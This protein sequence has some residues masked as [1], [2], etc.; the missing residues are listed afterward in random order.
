MNTLPNGVLGPIG[1]N[2][3]VW[4]LPLAT[5]T[6]RITNTYGRFALT[7][8]KALLV[9]EPTTRTT[10]TMTAAIS[11]TRRPYSTA[12]APRSSRAR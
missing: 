3:L 7:L 11:A 12:L 2:D 6:Y 8:E 5:R 9:F 4:S 10:A 1:S